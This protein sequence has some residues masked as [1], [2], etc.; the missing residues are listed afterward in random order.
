V[1]VIGKRYD[2]YARKEILVV[3]NEWAVGE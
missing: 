2:L 1:K 3:A